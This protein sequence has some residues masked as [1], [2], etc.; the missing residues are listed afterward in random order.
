MRV[1]RPDQAVKSARRAL[2]VVE[3]L[4]KLQRPASVAEISTR[5]GY[6]QSSTSGLLS[7]LRRLGY[8][9]YD[10][11]SRTYSLSLRVAL[12]GSNLRFGGY[13]TSSVFNLIKQI[14]DLT[15]LS[16]ALITRSEIYMQYV[17]T[18]RG[19]DVD[20]VGYEPGRLLPLCSTAG[21][22]ALLSSCSEIEL[23]K[24]VRRIN[25]EEA[26][27]ELVH[28]EAV[29]EEVAQFLQ[30]GWICISSRVF[31]SVGSVAMR[32]PFEDVFG[33]PLAITVGGRASMLAVEAENIAATIAE[34]IRAFELR[35]PDAGEATTG[36][37]EPAVLA[38]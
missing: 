15:N 31:G 9:R 37:R 6:P 21:G 23:G 24:I 4:E 27:R 25:A 1:V 7:G 26:E 14:H 29:M 11:G 35:G 28:Q 19:A 16:T 3:L 12:I 8:L 20:L 10:G 18:I 30:Q 5:L 13:A 32:L 17:Y 34:A 2:E 38:D 36:L 33:E 22:I